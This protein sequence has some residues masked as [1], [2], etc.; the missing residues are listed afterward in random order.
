MLS[1]V[2]H[3]ELRTG[4]RH[5]EQFGLVVGSKLARLVLD[6]HGNRRLHHRVG[7]HLEGLEQ[8]LL[9]LHEDWSVEGLLEVKQGLNRLDWG[10]GHHRWLVDRSLGEFG[11][12]WFGFR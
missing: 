9:R 7:L 5:A 1:L 4:G 12:L 10:L 8:I 2:V 6:H 11:S 3:V